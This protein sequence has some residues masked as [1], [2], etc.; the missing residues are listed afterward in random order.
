MDLSEINRLTQQA[1][2][3]GLVQPTTKDEVRDRKE[4]AEKD[5][6][7]NKK[8]QRISR[9][10]EIAQ[11]LKEHHVSEPGVAKA[12]RMLTNLYANAD[13]T[14]EDT[15]QRVIWSAQGVKLF[16]QVPVELRL[17]KRPALPDYRNRKKESTN[18]TLDIE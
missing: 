9:W 7:P 4:W 2:E 14:S 5:T 16:D 3:I 6:D 1:V 12:W 15:I 17:H 13:L 10:I 18:G 11:L 8:V